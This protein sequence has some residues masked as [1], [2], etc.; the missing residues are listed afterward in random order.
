VHE[1][2]DIL[3]RFSLEEYTWT[4]PGK[5][6]LQIGAFIATVF[7]LCGVVYLFYPDKPAVPRTFPHDGLTAALGGPKALPVGHPD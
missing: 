7:S 4:T 1:D 6:A 2:E 3:G 5:G